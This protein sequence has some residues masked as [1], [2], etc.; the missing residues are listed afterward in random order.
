MFGAIVAGRAV[1][2]NLQQIEPTKFVFELQEAASINHITVFLLPDTPFPDGYGATVYFSW[3]GKPFQLLGGLSNAKPSAI[4]KLGGMTAGGGAGITAGLGISVE[5][6]GAVDAQVT[7]LKNSTAAG[8]GA[9]TAVGRPTPSAGE[10]TTR[11]VKNLYNFLM[12]YAVDASAITP[13]EQFVPLRAFQ[14]WHSKFSNKLANDA[15]FLDRD[16]D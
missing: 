11:I 1:Q 4:F 14:E 16:Q 5:P 15:S 7:T 13:T 9:G 2:T 12:G 6:I 3:P 8:A 10:L